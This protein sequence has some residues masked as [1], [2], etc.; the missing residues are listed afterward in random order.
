MT[1]PLL[2]KPSPIDPPFSL[3]SASLSLLPVLFMKRNSLDHS[4][5]KGV[6][7]RKAKPVIEATEGPREPGQS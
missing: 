2:D 1:P 7:V 6:P 3:S 4:L 5:D